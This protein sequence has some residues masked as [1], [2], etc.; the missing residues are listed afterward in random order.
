MSLVGKWRIT[1]M[2]VW[3][4]D[5]VDLV[6]PGFIEIGERGGQLHFIAVDGLLECRHG[7]RDGRPRVEFTWEGN[8]ENEPASGRGWAKLLADGSVKGRVFIHQGDD[9]AFEAVPFGEGEPRS[10]TV[11]SRR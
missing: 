2:D 3:G 9:S 7:Q 5:A 8:D 11:R 4:Q 6:G 1:H 10:A